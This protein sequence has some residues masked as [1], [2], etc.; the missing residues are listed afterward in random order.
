MRWPWGATGAVSNDLRDLNGYLC[1]GAPLTGGS[2]IAEE[3]SLCLSR[4]EH[5]HDQGL[6]PGAEDVEPRTLNAAR[7]WSQHGSKE[8]PEVGKR[9]HAAA[10]LLHA[11]EPGAWVQSGKGWIR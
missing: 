2:A 4:Q 11:L 9:V 7:L 3:L 10:G 8:G 6:A 5:E 1:A